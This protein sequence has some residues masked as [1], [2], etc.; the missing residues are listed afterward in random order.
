MG[1]GK[2]TKYF[3]L[4]LIMILSLSV[5]AQ[6][7]RDKKIF[8]TT[9]EETF[10]KFMSRPTADLT[11]DEARNEYDF[12]GTNTGLTIKA[13]TKNAK[14]AKLVVTEGKKTH[15]FLIS[16]SDQLENNFFDFSTQ[17]LLEQAAREPKAA[18]NTEA[19]KPPA[20]QPA[21]GSSAD[22]KYI[23]LIKEG[24]DQFKKEM[25]EEAQA[26][27]KKALQ[28]VPTDDYANNR[29]KE[30]EQKLAEKKQKEQKAL[31]EKYTNAILKA[32]KAF[33][34][35]KYEDAKTAY[36]EAL[37]YRPNDQF[38]L[39]QI[40]SVDKTIAQ[41]ALI[42]KQNKERLQQEETYKATILNADKAFLAAQYDDAKTYYA[43][44][45][46]LNPN[47]IYPRNKLKETEKKI[48]DLTKEKEQHEIEIRR[49]KE[50]DDV[51]TEAITLADNAFKAEDYTVA[52]AEYTKAL[53]LKKDQRA[54]EQVKKIDSKLSE[55][56]MKE[57]TAR[58]KEQ[59]EILK[60]ENYKKALAKGDKAMAS[61]DYANAKIF[62]KLALNYKD[63]QYAKDKLSEIETLVSNLE[64]QDKAS[65]E[66]IAEVNESIKKYNSAIARGRTFLAEEDFI[67]AK[68]AY[69]EAAELKLAEQEP[70]TKLSTIN[71]RL[72]DLVKN[73]A[74]DSVIAKGNI[75]IG[76]KNYKL[77]A[78]YFTKALHAKPLDTYPLKQLQF[79]ET[80]IA[81][82]SSDKARIQHQAQVEVD[83]QVR[84][85]R[86]NQAMS[87]YTDYENAAQMANYEDQIFYLKQFLNLIDVKELYDYQFRP[88]GKIDFANKKIKDIRNY[89]T[90]I[91]GNS[92]QPEPI[93]YTDQELKIKYPKL[94]FSKPPSDQVF[95]R[96]DSTKL[97]ENFK[98][99]KEVLAE[100]SRLALS[101]SADNLKMT[102]QSISFKGENVYFKLCIKNYDSSDF[103]SGPMQLSVIKKDKSVIALRPAYVSN[104]PIILPKKEFF[105]VYVTKANKINNDDQLTLEMKD[106]F[107]NKKIK[108]NISGSVF[109][110]E[111]SRQS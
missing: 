75:A 81:R 98:I 99:S 70:K 102:C 27:F 20:E 32:A 82:D 17:K 80:L 49:K 65:K 86:F 77:A 89:L 39:N 67:S 104:F 55:L 76:E 59:K 63:E 95:D 26:S 79:V 58:E 25:Y 3:F 88:K 36:K 90:R 57:L 41:E 1:T 101:D 37:N 87:A 5:T 14:P 111:K 72:E 4:F 110:Q 66:K 93:P 29:L 6:E 28:F 46:T 97:I 47:E 105:I 106:I 103:L 2:N 23:S 61:K 53:K 9:G 31:D 12:F 100:N 7:I 24:N 13:K 51:F 43:L 52:K 64:L 30:I 74:Y 21:K 8:V 85:D 42:A 19:I 69:E 34:E 84:K 11:P 18:T 44:A 108:I 56:R 16:Y 10:L 33:S 92:Y 83:E 50:I 35:K 40:L 96:I 38:A 94:D 54:E 78:E 73:Q 109:N 71:K 107:K 68:A 15:I 45:A 48:A 22:E 60:T 62:Y 91:K